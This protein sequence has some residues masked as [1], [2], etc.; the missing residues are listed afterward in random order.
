MFESDK[1]LVIGFLART[2][3]LLLGL[4][5]ESLKSAFWVAKV[6]VYGLS[7]LAVGAA[8]VAYWTAIM[9]YTLCVV[10]GRRVLTWFGL[11]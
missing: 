11:E 9:L 3:R 7:I 5:W 2:Q 4:L 8:L 6:I 10:F 1:N